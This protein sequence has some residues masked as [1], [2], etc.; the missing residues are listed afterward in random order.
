MGP[1]LGSRK[2]KI[3]N[4]NEKKFNWPPKEYIQFIKAIAI[5]YNAQRLLKTL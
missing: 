5:K 4:A 3:L 1:S 2:T